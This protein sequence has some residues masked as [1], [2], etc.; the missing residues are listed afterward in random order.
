MRWNSSMVGK[1]PWNSI[2]T[3][4]NTNTHTHTHTHS[5][6]THVHTLKGHK[7]RAHTLTMCRSLTHKHTHTLSLSLRSCSHVLSSTNA[8]TSYTLVYARI[9]PYIPCLICNMKTHMNVYIYA[10]VYVCEQ[11]SIPFCRDHR[12]THTLS[13]FNSISTL[14]CLSVCVCVSLSLFLFNSISTLSCVCVCLSLSACLSLCIEK[15]TPATPWS[16]GDCCFP[17]RPQTR[18]RCPKSTCKCSAVLSLSWP[19]PPTL[20]WSVCVPGKDRCPHSHR[21][22]GPSPPLLCVHQCLQHTRT[23]GCGGSLVCIRAYRHR[24]THIAHTLPHDLHIETMGGC[25]QLC[26]EFMGL[27]VRGTL[28]EIS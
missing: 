18:C 12:H 7:T 9:P 26:G 2:L 20:S 6:H 1:A 22:A 10:H 28:Q 13:L 16:C 21:W 4:S 8:W 15:P 24:Y 14:F 23:C 25:F 5:L 11:E 17:H 3:H 19:T 27:C